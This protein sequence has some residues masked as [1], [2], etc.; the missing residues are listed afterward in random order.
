MKLNVGS[1]PHP[2]EGW[3]NLDPFAPADVKGDIFAL[4]FRDEVFT[5]IYLGHV[6]EHIEFTSV[7]RALREVR[8]VSQ[9]SAHVAIVGPCMNRAIK[10]KQPEWLLEQIKAGG[11]KGQPGEDHLWT[12]TESL[13]LVC[14]ISGG[15]L[16]TQ[17]VP[18]STVTRPEWPNPNTDP[19]QC[20]ILARTP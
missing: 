10:T 18:V 5:H 19:W 4:P 20:A 1:G 8:R 13:T 9:P 3:V 11:R 6:L 14:A 15:L 12:P 2:A 16:D 17:I 7:P